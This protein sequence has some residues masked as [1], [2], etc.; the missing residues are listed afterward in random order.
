VRPADRISGRS[1]I[2]I[3]WATA[4]GGRT[5]NQ[6]RAVIGTGPTVW[7]AVSDG[8]GGHAGG[9]RAAELTVSE[10]AAVLDRRPV[11]DPGS[12][13]LVARA[14]DR[15]NARVRVARALDVETAVMAATATIAVAL[16]IVPASSRWL[17]A[18]VG[19]SPAWRVPVRG[20]PQ[21]VT[22]EHNVAAELVRAGLITEAHARTHPGRHQITRAI[23]VED[24]A[25]PDHSEVTLT[26]GEALV[27]A[28]D[29]VEVVD[30]QRLAAVVTTAPSAADAASR[31]VGAALARQASDNV[32]V[33]MLR[34]RVA[35]RASSGHA[36]PLQ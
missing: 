30:D 36:P 21:R 5:E 29:G 11:P 12:P 10:L 32:T 9:A 15:A 33:I 28:S 24:T 3:G 14:L 6:D 35:D 13:A 2:E 16:D 34:H 7:V 23:G 4:I 31:L 25:E 18:N 27:L 22:R 8:A 17:I 26:P 20:G 19:D 1:I